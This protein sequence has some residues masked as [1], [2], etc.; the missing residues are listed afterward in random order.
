MLQSG[1]AYHLAYSS[2]GAQLRE[3]LLSLSM[4][5]RRARRGVWASDSTAAFPFHGLGSVCERGALVFPKLFRRCVAFCRE[6]PRITARE[7][8]DWLRCTPGQDDLVQIGA[9]RGRWSDL[10]SSGRER[11]RV[12]VDPMQIVFV[13][14]G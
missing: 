9:R 11:V 5:A 10:L 14:R 6:A 2:L 3:E 1:A 4:Q 8:V 13:P 7:L 12:S